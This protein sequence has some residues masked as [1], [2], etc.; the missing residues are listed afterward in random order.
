MLRGAA[1]LTLFGLAPMVWSMLDPT[2][3]PVLL[4]MTLGQL[5]GTF[6]FAMYGIAVLQDV[7]RIRSERRQRE[8]IVKPEPPA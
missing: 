8:Q 6:A 2:P 3:L 5:L 1:I 7:R 4:A